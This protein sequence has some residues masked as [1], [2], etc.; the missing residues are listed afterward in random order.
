MIKSMT[1]SL[2]FFV[3]FVCSVVKKR[4]EHEKHKLNETMRT[5]AR[6]SLDGT[7]KNTKRKGTFDASSIQF[8]TK[9]V[10]HMQKKQ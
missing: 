6:M 8:R 2:C 10:T 7:R 5:K 1:V 4:Y 9:F 3:S